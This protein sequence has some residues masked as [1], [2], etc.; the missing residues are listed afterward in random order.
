MSVAVAATSRA[1]AF[2][3]NARS[4]IVM[5]FSLF[6][7]P[8]W[9]DVSQGKAG[10]AAERKGREA[11]STRGRAAQA[12]ARKRPAFRRDA[13]PATRQS[14]S[15]RGRQERG[16]WRISNGSMRPKRD[17]AWEPAPSDHRTKCVALEQATKS[18]RIEHL[19]VADWP[20]RLLSADDASV[21][22]NCRQGR[23]PA[24]HPL[25]HSASSGAAPTDFHRRRGGSGF[26]N[27]WILDFSF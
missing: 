19:T 2:S 18:R 6:C 20:K 21:T 11:P 13:S 4:K 10:I 1:I 15:L 14:R 7:P 25:H 22:C 16:V 5:D 9:R 23:G 3:T 17:A 8:Q 24:V 27:L 12:Q 26:S